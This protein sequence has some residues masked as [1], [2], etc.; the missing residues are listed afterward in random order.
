MVSRHTGTEGRWDQILTETAGSPRV[1]AATPSIPPATPEF[2]PY[3][4]PSLPMRPHRS[5]SM[6]LAH[7]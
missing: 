6:A 3:L 2:P 5:G 7:G 4:Q 1:S